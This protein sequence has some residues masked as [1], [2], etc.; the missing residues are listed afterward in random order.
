MFIRVN[1]LGLKY[2]AVFYPN[3]AF[4]LPLE[5]KVKVWLE[6]ASLAETI[7]FKLKA[8]PNSETELSL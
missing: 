6:L 5:M 3:E 2:L 1:S 4:R 8:I 7:V